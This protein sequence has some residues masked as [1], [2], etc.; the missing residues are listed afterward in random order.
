MGQDQS[1]ASLRSRVAA[2]VEEEAALLTQAFELSRAG[3]DPHGVEALFARVQGMQVERNTLKKAIGSIL[4]NQRLHMAAEVWKAGVYD[5]RPEAGGDTI[6]V[7]VTKGPIGMQ[8]LMPGQSRPVS[9][10]GLEGSFDGPLAVDDDAAHS[11]AG[12]VEA[13]RPAEGRKPRKASTPAS[14]KKQ[15]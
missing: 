9:I 10:D 14:K 5:Y 12:P 11:Q 15:A 3:G 1:I 2:L 6:R 8:V 4:G 7:R 13:A